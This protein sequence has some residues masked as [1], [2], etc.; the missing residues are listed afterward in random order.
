MIELPE[1]V[2]LA[3]QIKKHLTGKTVV[4]VTAGKSP[5]GFAWFSSEPAGYHS[6]LVKKTITGTN[7][8][9]GMMEIV[10]GKMRLVFNDG[11]NL[12]FFTKDAKLPDK[13]Q[14]HIEFDDSSSFICS[15][16]M[17]GGMILL[18]D[19]DKDE[20]YYLSSKTKISP[21][22]KENTED[23][24]FELMNGVKPNYSIKAFLATEQRFPG[25]GNGVLQDILFNAKINP[26]RKIETL[27]S[28][29]KKAVYKN[30]KQTLNQMISGGGRDTE[31][32]IFGNTGGYKTILSTKTKALPC[33]VCGDTII[34]EA[35][36]GGNVYFCP[37]CQKYDKEKK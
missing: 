27:T 14:L 32:D 19:K 1:A 8:Y 35:F 16:Q 26:R 9:G 28:K 22:S 25:L 4:K 33:P 37:T 12:R 6:K 10:L 11:T 31:K 17:Y 36:L 30:V 21:V 29:E 23:Y 18:D 15:V 7:A 34:R 24:F 5:H 20:G 3:G 13:H 2:N